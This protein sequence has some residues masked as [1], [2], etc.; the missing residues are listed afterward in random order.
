MEYR[1]KY[2]RLKEKENKINITDKIIIPIEKEEK[3]KNDNGYLKKLLQNSDK[4]TKSGSINLNSYKENLPSFRTSIRDIL[5]TEE[6]KQKAINY[7]IQKR[8]EEKYGK[9]TNAINSQDKNKINLYSNNSNN[10]F[11]N[12]N[13][14]INNKNIYWF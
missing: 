10:Y 5:S 9:K 11:Y 12:S 14:K 1:R 7:V 2:L 8:N 3:P 13:S 4:T 6:N